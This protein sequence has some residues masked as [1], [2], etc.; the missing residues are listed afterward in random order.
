MI[1]VFFISTARQILKSLF[2]FIS[3]RKN[4]QIGA[5]FLLKKNVNQRLHYNYSQENIKKRSFICTQSKIMKTPLMMPNLD[6]SVFTSW[7][8]LRSVGTP[9]YRINL[10]RN[11]PK[12]K[13][14]LNN[15]S[16]FIPLISPKIT[17]YGQ[18]RN[19]LD[20][21]KIKK[22]MAAKNMDLL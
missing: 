12:W 18:I 3:V 14:K 8:N 6:S 7:R 13:K 22:I 19:F 15:M 5:T 9:V 10:W 21:T 16:I 17:N 4:G 20:S 1:N 11:T 2:K